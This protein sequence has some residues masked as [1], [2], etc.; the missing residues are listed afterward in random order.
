MQL[1]V[2]EVNM[3]KYGLVK[4]LKDGD[5]EIKLMGNAMTFVLY[6]SYFGRDLLNDIIEFARKNSNKDTIDKVL[7]LGDV[8]QIKE[9][10]AQKV[11]ESMGE[12]HFDTEF[13]LNFMAALIATAKYPERVSVADII[14]EIP[15]HFLVDTEIV[16][17]VVEFLSLFVKSKSGGGGNPANFRKK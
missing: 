13:I 12:F 7:A 11:L 3:N 1:M 15:P 6:K 16:S 9:S 14:M 2:R 5:H 4:T 17:E 10:E 8:T